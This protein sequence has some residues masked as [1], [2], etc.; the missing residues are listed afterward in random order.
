MR[1]IYDSQ[2]KK[3]EEIVKSIVQDQDVE[4][5]DF[6]LIAAPFNVENFAILLPEDLAER[7]NIEPEQEKVVEEARPMAGIQSVAEPLKPK[8]ANVAW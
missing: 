5:I 6:P 7:L 3:Y 1:Q 4:R 8:V 2:V